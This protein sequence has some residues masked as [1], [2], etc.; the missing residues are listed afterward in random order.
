MIDLPADE[1]IWEFSRSGGP[2]GQNVNKVETRVRLRFDPERSKA[3]DERQKERLRHAAVLAR[4]RHPTTG[5]LVITA[6]EYRTQLMNRTT[7]LERLIALLT[8]ALKPV[9]TRRPTKMP[10]RAHAKRLEAKKRRSHVRK[11]RSQRHADD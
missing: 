6:Q 10:K 4:H 8:Q 11:S 2:G 9:R 3:F 7:A 1:L 5:E